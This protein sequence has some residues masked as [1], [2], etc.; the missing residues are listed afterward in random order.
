MVRRGRFCAVWARCFGEASGADAID[1][2]LH[3][4][5]LRKPR[6]KRT[7]AADIADLPDG[8]FIADDGT[9]WLVQ[10]NALLAWSQLGYG[11][12]RKRPPHREVE[13][14]TPRSAVA[15]LSAGYNADVHPSAE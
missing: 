8:A 4:D 2:Q 5:R 11:A 12:Q 14:L 1:L 10:G 6:V 9:A 3:I 13:V 7:Y 15:V